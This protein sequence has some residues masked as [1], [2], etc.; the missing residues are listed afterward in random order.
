MYII[1]YRRILTYVCSFVSPPFSFLL[2]RFSSIDTPGVIR[3]VNELFRG[4]PP[5]IL[6]FNTF[7]PPGY[8]IELEELP[9]GV[10]AGVGIGPSGTLSLADPSPSSTTVQPKEEPNIMNMNHPHMGTVPITSMP[11]IIQQQQ[12]QPPPGMMPP[13]PGMM[14]PSGPLPPPNMRGGPLLPPPGRQGGPPVPNMSQPPPNIQH[15]G[16][17][18]GLPPPPP[19]VLQGPPP[20]PVRGAPSQHRTGPSGAGP[21][22]LGHA[23]G[24]VTR[25]KK[26]F[27]HDTQTY[28]TFLEILHTYQKQQNSIREVLE[29]VSLLFADHPDLLRDFTYFLPD[30]VQEQARERIQ[31]T[32]NEAKGKRDTELTSATGKRLGPQGDDILMDAGNAPGAYGRGGMDTGNGRPYGGPMAK[33]RDRARELERSDAREYTDRALEDR[34]L[35]MRERERDRE[36]ERMIDRA[37]DRGQVGMGPGK[38]PRMQV[39]VKKRRDRESDAHLGDLVPSERTFFDR[40][41]ATV[42]TREGWVE[43]LKVLELYST[44]VI[45]R[46]EL[47]QLVNDILPS[48]GATRKTL[49]DE[50]KTIVNNKGITEPTQADIWYSMPIA[51]V[52]FSACDKCTISYRH[53]PQ[54][55]PKLAVTERSR[56]EAEV[57]NDVWVSVPTGSEDFSFKIMRKNIYEDALFKC[58]DDRHEVDQCIENNAAAIRVLQPLYDEITTLKENSK[59]TEWQFRLD[60]RSLGVLHLKAISRVY[61]EHGYEILELLRKNPAG[62]IPIILARLKAKDEEWKRARVELNNTWRKIMVDN[63]RKSLDH[64]SFYFKG[65]DRKTIQPKN[66][67]SEIK[68]KVDAGEN[69]LR[70]W[71]EAEQAARI[72]NAKMN[73]AITSNED[74][75][76]TT[77][78]TTVPP[79]A[80]NAMDIDTTTTTTTAATTTTLSS[81]DASTSKTTLPY[82]TTYMGVPTSITAHVLAENTPLPRSLRAKLRANEPVLHFMY[83]DVSMH[84][85]VYNLMFYAIERSGSPA[86]KRACIDMWRTF[87]SPYFQLPR[88]QLLP[89]PL[90]A[91]PHGYGVNDGRNGSV[92]VQDGLLQMGDIVTTPYGTGVIA[93]VRV[94]MYNAKETGTGSNSSSTTVPVTMDTDETMDTGSSTSGTSNTDKSL[95]FYE[96]L[97][98][99]ARATL[100]ASIVHLAPGQVSGNTIPSSTVHPVTGSTL[101]SSTTTLIG[102]KV[103]PSTIITSSTRPNTLSS[104]I[105]S[106]HDNGP[107]T[108]DGS[109]DATRPGGVVIGNTRYEVATPP[110]PSSMVY[111]TGSGYIFFRLHQMI[112]DRL[113]AARYYCAHGKAKDARG[114]LHPTDRIV[115]DLKK[116]I[117]PHTS[118]TITPSTTTVSSSIGTAAATATGV[119]LPKVNHGIGETGATIAAAAGDLTA[120]TVMS[121][122]TDIRMDNND[123]NSSSSSS[124]SS[125]S[126]SAALTEATTAYTHFLTNIYHVLDGSLDINS[127][128]DDCRE[129]MG[130]NA[131]FFFTIDKV[132]T[133]AAKQLITMVHEHTTKRVISLW[134]TTQA[135]IARATK[136]KTGTEAEEGVK[137]ALELYRKS[138]ATALLPRMDERTTRNPT[139]EE[140]FAIQYSMNTPDIVGNDHDD[141]ILY[142]MDELPTTSNTL[143]TTTT[144]NTTT[145]TTTTTGGGSST[146]TTPIHHRTAS[147]TIRY[148]GKPLSSSNPLLPL[149]ASSATTATPTVTK[150]FQ[151]AYRLP[152]YLS[153]T[154]GKHRVLLGDENTFIENEDPEANKQKDEII[155]GPYGLPL[156]PPRQTPLDG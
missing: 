130:T 121:A 112:V 101:P 18:G 22:E 60:R 9:N 117:N 151:Y 34:E 123:G 49:I 143:S 119:L 100:N 140:A 21:L 149:S 56:M 91:F 44:E 24:Y 109:V 138:I 95:W 83:R 14:H 43:F 89:A 114:N 144:T 4:Y 52:D 13:P 96:V 108:V 25:I 79:S 40:M 62:A 1:L 145:I 61:G 99:Y 6:G 53:L 148:C 51:E 64:R 65:T 116:G 50:F 72:H 59:T 2:L 150:A 125:R 156:P 90:A 132:I 30:S 134:E 71:R 106:S 41:K 67:L 68:G 31:R 5:L 80:T 19:N 85:E 17:G 35:S 33:D 126:T 135:R 8:K 58:E 87:F 57:L 105:S 26:R 103:K 82:D 39:V 107:E 81:T 136:T 77:T 137:Q 74:G 115:T 36:R 154:V 146:T 104:S 88:Q 38:S 46:T 75:S 133:S 141:D 3:R 11:N 127:F 7:L 29:R 155:I 120:A 111:M 28:K 124:S 73:M 55:Y 153:R 139:I 37:R 27:V 20:P 129:L 102:G 70:I 86:D 142:G 118:T 69:E 15:G 113:I 76:L 48:S 152:S 42:G 128:E 122:T 110:P 147:L 45:N 94:G 54:G 12:Q 92:T 84:A 47:F 32:L 66:L 10:I 78:T 97:L 93:H 98:D 63:Y 16:G 131:Y 23:M